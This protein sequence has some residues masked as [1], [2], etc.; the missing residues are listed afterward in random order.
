MTEQELMEGVALFDV[1]HQGGKGTHDGALEEAMTGCAS[2]Q[3]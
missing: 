3:H 2:L 1:F